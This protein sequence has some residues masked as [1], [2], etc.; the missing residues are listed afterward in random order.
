MS[1]AEHKIF[2]FLISPKFPQ[3]SLFIAEM[4]LLHQKCVLCK[5]DVKYFAFNRRMAMLSINVARSEN[6]SGTFNSALGAL[7]IILSF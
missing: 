3:L 6:K 2:A 7:S 5:C 4:M 1:A